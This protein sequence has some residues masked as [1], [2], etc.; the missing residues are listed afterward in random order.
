MIT[1]IDWSYR[2]YAPLLTDPGRPYICRVAPGETEIFFEWL[3]EGEKTAYTVLFGKRGGEM[4]VLG[5]T[6]ACAYRVSGLEEDAEYQFQVRCEHGASR[7][8]LAR[9]GAVPGTVVNYLHP[10]DP[11]YAFSGRYL[12]SPSL[13]RHPMGHLLASMDLFGPAPSPQN[14]TLIF[15][16]DDDGKTWHY[17]TELFPCFWGKMFIHQGKLYM[18]ACST[19]YGDL[20]IGCS[21]DG[22]Y[23]FSAPKVLLRGSGRAEYP[24]VHKNPQPVV[25]YAGRVWNT[26][27]WGCWHEGFHAAMVMSADEGADLLDEKSWRFSAPLPYD[28]A[29]PG[30]ARGK[31]AGNIE[32]TLTVAP[33]GKLYNIMRYDMTNCQP[34]FGRVLAYRVNEKDPDAALAYDHAIEFPANH[35]KFTI[36]YDEKSRCYWSIANRILGA[37]CIRNRNLL[38]LLV[39]RDLEHWQVALDL[40]D[41]RQDDPRF[42]GF[43]Y[44][45]FLMEGDD[46]LYLCRTALNHPHSF[47]D[48]NYSTFHRLKDFRAF[49]PPEL[50]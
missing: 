10:D 16:S 42:T 44:V 45:D 36:K 4:R 3:P 22:G 30:T 7:V 39:S 34:S 9:T 28:P 31:S 5:R 32:G 26:L 25:A 43:Q 37:D 17:V 50:K 46:L 13:V 18:L 21:E 11:C 20:L 35:S 38:S 12:C 24:G 2:P 49:L 48:S 41:R 1:H 14:L 33:D 8:R 23:T 47:H 15:R 6:Q 19:E 40:I 29:W 27:E